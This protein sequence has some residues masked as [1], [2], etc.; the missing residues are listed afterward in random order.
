MVGLLCRILL[1][2]GARPTEKDKA[3]L[4][5]LHWSGL[6]GDIE[7]GPQRPVLCALWF[8]HI[9]FCFHLCHAKSQAE[10]ARSNKALYSCYL[11][12]KRSGLLLLGTSPLGAA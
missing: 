10:G 7:V 12:E 6:H 5:P 3:W 9:A 8:F 2:A 1:V 11:H 4:T